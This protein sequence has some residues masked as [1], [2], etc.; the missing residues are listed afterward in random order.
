MRV[1]TGIQPSGDLHIGNYF[2]AIKQM[3]DAQNTSEM[4]IFIANYHAMTSLQNGEKLKE[5]SIKAAAAFLSFGIDPQKSVFWLQSDVKEV[6]ELYW[7]LSQFTPMGLLERAH[8]YKDKIAKGLSA[9]HGLFSYPVLM[10][11]DILLF[12]TQLVPV[13]K[14]QIQHVEIARD[15]ALKVNNEWGEIFILPEAKINEDLAV[16]VGTDGA[17][18]SKSYK[19]T[20]DIF[21]DDK[22]LKKQI[23]SIVTDS[24]ALEDPKNPEEC[25]VFKIAKLFLDNEG[26]E[27]LRNRYLKGG[28]GYGHFKMYLNELVIDYFKEI[29][30]KYNELLNKPS[31]LK[32][33]LDFGASKARKIAQEKMQKIYTKI[34]L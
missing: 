17:K 8:S 14:D 34:G 16:I 10:A 9:S 18:M 31:Y 27:N 32:E 1:L 19:N 12:D 33:V 29:R 23:S 2:G 6:M 13:G 4:F 20:I 26:Q 22:T 25:N 21:N 11:A 24:T 7:I 30:E 15:I 28:E 3:I 5:N